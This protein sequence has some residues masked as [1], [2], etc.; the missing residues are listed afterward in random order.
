MEEKSYYPQKDS[1]FL[2]QLTIT[3]TAYI[4]VCVCLSVSVSRLYNLKNIYIKK[5]EREEHIHS[6]SIVSS[7]RILLQNFSSKVFGI[8]NTYFHR[9]S[10]GSTHRSLFYTRAVCLVTQSCLTFCNHMDYTA[11]QA[12]LSTGFSRQEHRSGLPLPFPGNLPHPGT[13]PRVSC[14]AAGFLVFFLTIWT[15]REAH[16]TRGRA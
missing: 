5:K 6:S 14:I 8:H 12:P 7:P 11:C 15:T 4:Y 3:Y 9:N 1:K 10:V 16:L 2:K 13:V